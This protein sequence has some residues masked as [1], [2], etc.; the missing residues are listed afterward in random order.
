MELKNQPKLSLETF[1]KDILDDMSSYY[2]IIINYAELHKDSFRHIFRSLL[3]GPNST[4]NSFIENIKYNWD[5]GREFT[6]G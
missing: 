4:L 6:A 2:S 1:G 5:T 3:P